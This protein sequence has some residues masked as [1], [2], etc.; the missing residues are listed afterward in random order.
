M[1]VLENSAACP[2]EGMPHCFQPTFSL[3]FCDEFCDPIR[4]EENSRVC[5]FLTKD[6]QKKIR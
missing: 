3:A 6:K 5:H 2:E 1:S 4:M